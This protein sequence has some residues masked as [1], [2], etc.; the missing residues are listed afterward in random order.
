MKKYYIVSFGNSNTYSIAAPL[1][2]DTLRDRIVCDLKKKFPDGPVCR[3]ATIDVHEVDEQT[4]AK[5]PVLDHSAEKAIYDI[6][7]REMEVNADER[8][9]N[10][11]AP[12]AVTEKENLP[13]KKGSKEVYPSADA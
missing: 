6:L 2:A 1:D 12:Y 11:N 4:A 7:K 9:L 8:E 5:Y 3:I 10:N 13:K